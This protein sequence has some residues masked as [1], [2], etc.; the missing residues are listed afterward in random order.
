MTDTK[1]N[2]TRRIA[3]LDLNSEQVEAIRKDLNT[4][5]TMISGLQNDIAKVSPSVAGAILRNFCTSG[6]KLMNSV[7]DQILMSPTLPPAPI[8]PPVGAS[9]SVPVQGA[10][11]APTDNKAAQVGSDKPVPGVK[12]TS[13]TETGNKG[14]RSAS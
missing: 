4:L 13:S 6:M 9:L 7:R 12:E 3:K 14:R 8:M 2:K 11:Q 1:K 10:S 5:N